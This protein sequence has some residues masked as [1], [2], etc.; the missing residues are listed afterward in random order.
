MGLAAALLFALIVGGFLAWA[1]RL[2]QP[3]QMAGGLAVA[4]TG[5]L[6][7]VLGAT[8][9]GRRSC[10]AA[11]VVLFAYGLVIPICTPRQVIIGGG[12]AMAAVGVGTA[13]IQTWQ[14]RKGAYEPVAH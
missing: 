11:A 1:Q 8:G 13:A 14:L 5:G 4:M 10:F 6:C 2:G 12:A 9:P 7:A 3:I